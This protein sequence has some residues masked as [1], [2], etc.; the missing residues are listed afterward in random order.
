MTTYTVKQG[1]T[2]WWIAVKNGISWQKL[3][4][5]NKNVITDPN[6]IY[7]GMVLTI[8]TYIDEVHEDLVESTENFK[9]EDK[10]IFNSSLYDI[11]KN[12][13]ANQALDILEG[14][15]DDKW[16]DSNSNTYDDVLPHLKEAG[17]K[18]EYN[19]DIMKD[20]NKYKLGMG[21]DY[22]D[23][24]HAYIFITTPNLNLGGAN[25][26]QYNFESSEFLNQMKKKDKAI[27]NAL[28][29]D[30]ENFNPFIPLLSNRFTNF[31][32]KDTVARTKYIG[33]TFSG[34]KQTYPESNIES[35]V[36][37]QFQIKFIETAN[38]DITKLHKVWCDYIEGVRRGMLLPS[39]NTINSG[40]VDYFSSIYYFMVKPD[41][42]TITYFAKYTG[43][44]P[45]NVPYSAYS[46]SE[47]ERGLVDVSI[48]YIYSYKED[49][50]PEIISDF[51]TIN[52]KSKKAEIRQVPRKNRG[53]NEAAF[54]YVIEFNDIETKY[55]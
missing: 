17:V 20:F 39:D 55:K 21:D 42:K 45:I 16:K 29:T 37:D 27:L 12:W 32:T 44:A 43:V 38:M 34:F 52:K 35:V 40:V 50:E 1:D 26:S 48:Q 46:Y 41:G 2:L 54:D 36:S 8:K 19:L 49:M 10:N 31:E 47:G 23:Q 25:N 51:N 7:P 13:V 14:L 15:A 33:E 3:Y 53:N 24:G 28:T 4:E 30:Q 5:D 9:K 11:G 22:L 6:K 18:S